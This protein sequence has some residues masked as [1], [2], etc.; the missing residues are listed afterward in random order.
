M[1]TKA[2]A[3]F[4]RYPTPPQE[5]VIVLNLSGVPAVTSI[6]SL[7]MAFITSSLPRRAMSAFFIKNISYVLGDKLVSK[8]TILSRSCQKNGCLSAVWQKDIRFSSL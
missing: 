7:P 3:L 2:T 5:A 1:K 6:H 4:H 8:V